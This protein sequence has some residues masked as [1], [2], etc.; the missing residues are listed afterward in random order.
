MLIVLMCWP[1]DGL[2][3][4]AKKYRDINYHVANTVTI[5]SL[6]HQNNHT[7]HSSTSASQDSHQHIN[8]SQHIDTVININ[9]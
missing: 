6:T 9:A 4:F 5:N 8:N 7:H 1:A 3:F 2:V